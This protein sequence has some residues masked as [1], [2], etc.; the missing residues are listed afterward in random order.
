MLDTGR[1]RA[2]IVV[3]DDNSLSPKSFYDAC[4]LAQSASEGVDVIGNV[5]ESVQKVAESQGFQSTNRFSFL[6]ENNS[7]PQGKYQLLDEH[8]LD[9]DLLVVAIGNSAVLNMYISSRLELET[10]RILQ[11]HIVSSNYARY[12][13]LDQQR[14][15][16]AYIPKDTALWVHELCKK[17]GKKEI[18]SE[19]DGIKSLRALVVGE[20][21][22]DE[23][24]YCNALG[25]V[26]KDPL[27]A[28]EIGTQTSQL[29][30]ILA[31]AKHVSG[32]GALTSV[33]S[34]VGMSDLDS[35]LNSLSPAIDLAHVL[36]TDEN[37][38][39]KTRYVDRASNVRVF[40]TYEMP[41]KHMSPHIE[42]LLAGNPERVLSQYDLAVVVDYGHGLIDEN[43][44][45][46][47][48]NSGI[49]LAVNAQSNAGNRG[50]NPVSRY[51][52]SPMIFLNGSEVEVETRTRSKDLVSTAESLA[53]SLDTKEFYVTNG[54][55]GLICWQRGQQTISVPAFAPSV[56][57]RTGAG[58]ALLSITAL[59]R[60]SGTP[61][62]IAAFF[63]NI[64]G[65]LLIS[66]M[67]N[68]TS[69]SYESVWQSAEEILRVVE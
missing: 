18:L 63:G 13:L 28:F 59:L 54:S 3:C 17:F 16:S 68:E 56:V 49:F 55:G 1:T 21:I 64:A 50:F 30:G 40:E 47:L 9:S 2:V 45:S 12:A 41:K 10:R 67:G 14:S 42:S 44:I 4:L 66:S 15:L 51:R 37:S 31:V 46:S 62:E 6:G 58:D 53:E 20:T 39:K 43:S 38:L 35:I 22:I 26:S 32:L 25:K 52:G 57:D 24:V 65:A 23:Y 34:Q 61:R 60:R 8:P 69:L 27:V 48:I 33:R 36:K 7:S 11:W 19:L 29:G 5:P